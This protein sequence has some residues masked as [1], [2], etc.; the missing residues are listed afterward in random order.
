MALPQLISLLERDRTVR[1]IA[2]SVVWILLV[3][4]VRFGTL[5][6]LRRTMPD[7]DRQKLRITVQVRRGSLAIMLLGLVIIWMSELRT[8]ALS[9]TAILVAIVIATKEMLL[10]V[11]GSILRA[12]SRAFT[13]GDRIE[14]AGVRGD[15]ID[16]GLIATS[17]LEVGPGHQWTGRALTVPN[18]AFLTS[19]I[20]NETESH[21]FVLHV[22]R[23]PVPWDPDWREVEE[24]LRAAGE[25]ISAEYLDEA[26]SV[27]EAEGRRQGLGTPSVEPRVHLQIPETGELEFLLRLPC[28]AR[29][30]GEIEQRVLRR[31]L[32]VL[33]DRELGSESLRSLRRLTEPPSRA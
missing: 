12:S 17:I 33:R 4:A 22:I 19:P 2:L 14:V 16:H 26:R 13:V 3:L 30:K 29:D 1:E 21:Q 7:P 25:A 8:V 5:R 18:S 9:I 6:I 31:F 23:V 20:V 15:V 24:A 27:I 10:C 28:R 11:M 32:D